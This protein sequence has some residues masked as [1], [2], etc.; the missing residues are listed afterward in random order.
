[1]R[2]KIIFVKKYKEWKKK[3][4]QKEG[5]KLIFTKKS[6][7]NSTAHL[8]ILPYLNIYNL[9]FSSSYLFFCVGLGRR[10]SQICL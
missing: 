10:W 8:K 3:W 9:V 4:R 2:A 6:I 5:K 1:M 7:S